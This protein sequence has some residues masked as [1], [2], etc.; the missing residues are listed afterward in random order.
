MIAYLGLTADSKMCADLKRAHIGRIQQRG[1]L[2]LKSIWNGERWAFDNGAFADFL[3]GREFDEKQ[4]AAD[5]AAVIDCPRRPCIVVV[6]DIVGGGEKSLAFSVEWRKRLP[7]TWPC[8]LAVQDGMLTESVRAV[9]FNQFWRGIFLGGTDEFKAN[10]GQHY[11]DFAHDHGLLFHY[12]RAS[13]P[14]KIRHAREI[15]ADSVDSSFPL[16]ERSRFRD[17]LMAVG[18]YS[19]QASIDFGDPDWEAVN[20]A[21]IELPVTEA[22]Q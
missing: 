21:A 5:V 11:C 12:G 20:H 10:S 13:T 3:A 18:A 8:Y 1:Q 22:P 4:Y 2:R 15:G 17:F 19:I 6:P 14:R 16:W 7:Q 9:C